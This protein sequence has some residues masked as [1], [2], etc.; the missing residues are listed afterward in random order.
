MCTR[1]HAIAPQKKERKK[2][3]IDAYIEHYRLL[4][5]RKQH[6]SCHSNLFVVVVKTPSL[7]SKLLNFIY[8]TLMKIRALSPQS[9]IGERVLRSAGEKALRK[10]LVPNFRG[11]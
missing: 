8:Q 5:Q 1:V 7:L 4:L 2:Q 11:L 10:G 3:I 6:P 9:Q